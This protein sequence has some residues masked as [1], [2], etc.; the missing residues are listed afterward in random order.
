MERSVFAWKWRSITKRGRVQGRIYRIIWIIVTTRLFA[1]SRDEN[2]ESESSCGSTDI[3]VMNSNDAFSG[4]E[5][6][7][8][9]MVDS[10]SLG[11]FL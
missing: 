8:L 6:P 11:S 3:S 1:G 2:E 10:S 5:L 9:H 7:F 4:E